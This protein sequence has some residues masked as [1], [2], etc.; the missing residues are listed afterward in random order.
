MNRIKN[1]FILAIYSLSVSAVILSATGCANKDSAGTD[2]GST[3]SDVEE[4]YNAWGRTWQDELKSAHEG[5]IAAMENVAFFYQYGP[6]SVR[7]YQKAID[8]YSNIIDKYSRSTDDGTRYYEIGMYELGNI[9]LNNPYDEDKAEQFLKAAA[10]RN[11]IPAV[12]ALA[13]FY[14]D[15]GREGEAIDLF[16]KVLILSESHGNTFD[17]EVIGSFFAMFDI[18][19]QKPKPVR[20]ET[21]RLMDILYQDDVV[22]IDDDVATVRWNSEAKTLYKYRYGDLRTLTPEEEYQAHYML[23]NTPEGFSVLIDRFPRSFIDEA[24]RSVKGEVENRKEKGGYWSTDIH[25]REVASYIGRYLVGLGEFDSAYMFLD[26]AAENGSV[27]AAAQLAYFVYGNPS[28]EFGDGES[29]WPESY[30][31]PEKAQKYKDI[32]DKFGYKG[33]SGN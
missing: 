14:Y 26:W 20:A 23:S 28:G 25:L 12:K 3:T 16:N 9:Y 21:I 32:V 15:S 2:Q 17:K 13:H 4:F 10:D 19:L 29:V 5:S 31:D 11:Y 33:P 27:D 1:H 18:N 24:I 30:R 7:D 22:D 6:F 8:Y